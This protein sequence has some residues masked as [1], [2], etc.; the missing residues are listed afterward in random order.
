L[1]NFNRS[2]LKNTIILERS[3]DELNVLMTF[4]G[5]L[6]A[7]L[8][9]GYVA[10]RLKLSPIV[11][12]LLAG[13]AVGPF[14]PGF[15]ANQA[16]AEQFAEIGV[17]LLLFG[18]GLRFHLQELIAV[19]R[20]AVPGAL[21]Q[22]GFSTALM[23]LLL[24]LLGWS[25][26]SGIVLGLAISVASTVVMALVLAERRDLHAPIGHIAIGWTVVEDILTV[27]Y[28]LLLPLVFGPGGGGREAG[29]ALALTAL[30]I[31]GPGR[32]GG[33]P[34]PLGDSPGP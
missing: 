8:V 20:I 5:G 18:I 14:T 27:T 7:A 15:T 12:Y 1:Q 4:A 34:G 31:R 13:I 26:S 33:G 10:Q 6:A 11:G 23:V 32:F 28:L 17:I 24:R 29:N 3:M 16:V 2:Y 25:W 9:L 30:K 19:W 21:I 22:S